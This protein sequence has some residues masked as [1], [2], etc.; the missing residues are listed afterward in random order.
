MTR[1][2]PALNNIGTK[3]LWAKTTKQLKVQR[4]FASVSCV[5]RAV[6]T[7]RYN[8]WAEEV[9]WMSNWKDVVPENDKITN[10]VLVS[11]LIYTDF[12]WMK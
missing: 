5:P 9:L 1:K 12:F 4:R 11:E 10:V 8:M 6:Q 2:Q 7:L 3:P